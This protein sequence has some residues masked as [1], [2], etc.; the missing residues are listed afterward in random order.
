MHIIEKRTCFGVI[1]A[2]RGFFNPVFTG[3][4][5]KDIAALLERL[6]YDYVIGAE[7]DTPHGAVETLSDAKFYAEQLL[8]VRAL[9]E[10]E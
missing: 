3:S 5:R 9:F 10:G 2:T 7:G 6:D 4:A 1:I 8:S